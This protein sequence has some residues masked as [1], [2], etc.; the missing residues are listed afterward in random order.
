VIWTASAPM[1]KGGCS[2]EIAGINRLPMFEGTIGHRFSKRARRLERHVPALRRGSPA[3]E[4][5]LR[6]ATDVA[7]A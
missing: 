3:A 5:E 7:P 1:P 4:R 6:Q 2:E